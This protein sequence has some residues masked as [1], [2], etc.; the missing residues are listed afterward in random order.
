PGTLGFARSIRRAT[1]A[2]SSPAGSRSG[3]LLPHL[4]IV[5]SLA[6]PGQ[7]PTGFRTF[8]I[9]PKDLPA[10]LRQGERAGKPPAARGGGDP[11]ALGGRS[12]MSDLR[13]REFMALIGSAACAWPLAARAQQDGTKRQITVWMGRAND[14]EGQRHAAAFREAL[15]ALGWADRRNVQVHY[16]W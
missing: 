8:Q 3:G 5:L 1:L 6:G 15:Q 7:R 9:C 11:A 12:Q 16:H 14:A 10:S 4:R 2:G 13:R